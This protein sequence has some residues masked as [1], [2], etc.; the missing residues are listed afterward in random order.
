MKDPYQV[1]GVPQSATDEEI[2]TA[3]RNLARKYHPDKYRDSDLADLANEKM[4]E[5]NEAYD[6]IKKQR[7]AGTSSGSGSGAGGTGSYGPQYGNN[8]E[9]YTGYRTDRTYTARELFG[10]AR[11]LINAG[12]YLEAEQLLSTVSESQRTAEWYFLMGWVAFGHRHFVDAQQYFDYACGLDPE[13]QEYR[14][15][16]TRLREQMKTGNAENT[17]ANDG[18]SPCHLCAGLMCLNLCCDM[19]H[20]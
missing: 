1:L 15:A 3:Y 13:N 6:E 16:Q 2:K 20:C 11:Q 10:I 7:A 14:E 8:R 17:D 12:R 4:K 19:R 5:I 9:S 18:C